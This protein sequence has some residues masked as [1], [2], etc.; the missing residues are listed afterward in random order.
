ML[1]QAS[2]II[3]AQLFIHALKLPSAVTAPLGFGVRSVEGEDVSPR[4]RWMLRLLR[5]EPVETAHTAKRA[6][7]DYMSSN[8]AVGEK[9]DVRIEDRT[10]PGTPDVAIRIYRPH[11]VAD[12]LPTLLWIHGGGWVIGS[13]ASHDTFCRRLC[14]EAG[15]AVVA[16]DYRLAPEHPFPAPEEDVTLVWRWMR[17]AASAEG[18]D[19]ERLGMGGDSAGGNLTAVLCQQLPVAERPVSQIL[20]YPSTDSSRIT[21]SKQTWSK[22]YLLDQALIH[23]FLE[24]YCA[25]QALDEPRISP[26]L[27][28]DLSDQPSAMVI[29]AGMDPLLDEGRAYADR[30]ESA[31]V[32]VERYHIAPMIHGFITLYG[33]LPEADQAVGEIITR[34]GAR[35]HV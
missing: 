16:V 26:L 24:R 25:G 22:G 3:R 9:H 23:W 13:I 5:L 1:E 8:R 17:S 28:P 15:I 34:I 31:G 12:P 11:D 30:L 2:V 6:I 27:T 7:F 33:L 35:L 4:L 21:N 14:V 19:P 18:F 29:T 32:A 10:V 20:C